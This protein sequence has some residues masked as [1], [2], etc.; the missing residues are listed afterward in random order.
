VSDAPIEVDRYDLLAPIGRGGFGAVY[1]AR[2]KLT[3]RE[4]ALKLSDPKGDPEL[5]A[6]ALNEARIAATIQHPSLVSV[7]DCGALDDGRIFVVMDRIDGP[8]LEQLASHEGRLEPARAVALVDQVLSALEVLHARGVVH[9]DIKPSNV[10]VRREM[11]GRERA[12]LIDFGISKSDERVA[13]AEPAHTMAGSILGTPGYM[14]PEQFDARSVDARADLF[15]VAAVLYRIISGRA[16]IE[17]NS[18]TD[19]LVAVTQRPLP[20]LSLSAP[21]VQ[22]ALAAVIDRALARD[23]DARPPDAATMRA[24]LQSA[25]GGDGAAS[26]AAKTA[27]VEAISQPLPPAAID[28]ARAV[29]VASPSVS[30]DLRSAAVA[31]T[32]A[33]TAAAPRRGAGLV[34]AAAASITIGAFALLDRSATSTVE[35]DTSTVT[36]LDPAHRAALAAAS[37]T[38]QAPA[39]SSS[40]PSVSS[41]PPAASAVAIEPTPRAQPPSEATGSQEQPTQSSVDP[42]SPDAGES[43]VALLRSNSGRLRLVSVRPVGAVD[44]R[45]A[46]DGVRRSLATIESCR[47]GAGRARASITIMFRSTASPVFSEPASEGGALARCVEVAMTLANPGWRSGTRSDG[48]LADVEFVWRWR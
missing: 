38:V 47:A 32:L 25:L 18:I 7:Y 5:V 41:A 17:C 43:D 30:T 46:L 44:M 23:R 27:H 28:A 15:S 22:P 33:T 13:S 39:P 29:V 37:T 24:W 1:L 11:D 14:P 19:W 42:V 35:D 2:H 10:L 36:T 12:F 9:R 21:W 6:R 4:V 31:D 16:V 45:E 48:I 26:F 34:L 40:V 8:S 20:S 3:G